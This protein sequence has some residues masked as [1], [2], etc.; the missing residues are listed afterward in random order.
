MP[1][2]S[3]VRLPGSN[4]TYDIKDAVARQAIAGGISYVI[5]WKGDSTPVVANI[6]AGV[7]VTYNGTTYTGTLA[8]SAT[9]LGAFYLVRSSTQVGVNDIYDEYATISETS[10]STTSYSWEK[11]G[12]THVDLSSLGNLAY[13]DTANVTFTGQ[14]TDKVI[15]SDST[16]SVTQPTITVTPATTNIKATASGTAV[17]ADG[18]ASAV[19]GYANPTTDNFVKS[20]S[21]ETGN[22]L[23]TT[24]VPNVTSAGSASTWSFAM[25]TGNDSETLIISGA[26]SVAPTL[27]TAKTV[28][29]GS[30]SSSGTGSAVVTGV[31]I[32][33]SAAAITGLGSPST[34]TV[35]KGVKVTSQ[36]SVALVTGATAGTGVISVATGITSATATGGNVA[37][38]S[39]DEVTA[40]TNVGTGTAS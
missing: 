30:V 12:D 37:W 7:V 3:K 34:E 22:K 38:N 33:E 15:G 23:V 26:N 14:T 8:A 24:T 18:T 25:G 36:P 9:T 39:K 35:L 19:T 31:T 40:I 29:T 27:G 28:A 32:G 4:Q 13:K 16:F 5:A 17:G 2:I 21:A 20:V 10:G 11:I 6:P 1:D